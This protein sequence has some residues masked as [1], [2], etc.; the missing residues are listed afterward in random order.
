MIYLPADGVA[1]SSDCMDDGSTKHTVHVLYKSPVPT[2]CHTRWLK[3]FQKRKQDDKKPLE[4]KVKL[5]KKRNAELAAIARRLEEK[6]KNLQ[7]E[8]LQVIN[9]AECLSAQ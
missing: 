7:K 6:A 2:A 8:N 9:T 5:L 3:L 1:L 4:E